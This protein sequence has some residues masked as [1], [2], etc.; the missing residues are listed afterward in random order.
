[1]KPNRILTAALLA[2]FILLI[3]APPAWAGSPQSYRWEGL[4][5]GVGAA[6]IGSTLWKAYH[7]PQR[8][9]APRPATTH[10]YIVPPPEPNGHWELR[11]QWVPPTYEKVWNP[12]H[13]NRRGRWVTGHWMRIESHPGHWEE[14]RVWVPYK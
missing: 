3:I 5:M 7:Q 1:M 6:I 8:H 4:A 12:G 9:H 2:V 14:R 13:Y 10:Q 11:K